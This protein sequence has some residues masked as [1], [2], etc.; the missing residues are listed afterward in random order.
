MSCRFAC[1]TEH[2]YMVNSKLCTRYFLSHVCCSSSMMINIDQPVGLVASWNRCAFLSIVDVEITGIHKTKRLHNAGPGLTNAKGVSGSAGCAVFSVSASQKKQL[3]CI[4]QT[5][6]IL[7]SSKFTAFRCCNLNLG[8]S[9]WVTAF[10]SC[11]F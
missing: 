10:T 2:F 4:L 11:A 5:F 1:R 7:T 8:A 6:Q 9:L 3:G